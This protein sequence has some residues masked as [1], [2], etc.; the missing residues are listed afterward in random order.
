[1]EKDDPEKEITHPSTIKQRE[2]YS[3]NKPPQQEQHEYESDSS[4]DDE[5][6]I[7]CGSFKREELPKKYDDNQ[8][9]TT[10]SGTETFNIHNCSLSGYDSIRKLK[11]DEDLRAPYLDLIGQPRAFKLSNI[12]LSEEN[13][14]LGDKSFRDLKLS[15]QITANNRIPRPES[16]SKRRSTLK[17]IAEF[18]ENKDKEQIELYSKY[19]KSIL[20]NHPEVIKN[21]LRRNDSL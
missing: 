5:P 2:K 8:T 6:S 18:Q 14:S 21:I 12:S 19:L 15:A 10:I 3:Y 16:P 9:S 20:K 7:I 11:E 13:S 17:G 4:S 1:M